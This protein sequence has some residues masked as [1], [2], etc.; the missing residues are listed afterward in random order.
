VDDLE[1]RARAYLH[2]N[3]TASASELRRALRCRKSV[4]LELASRIRS[5]TNGERPLTAGQL[6]Q[7]RSAAVKTGLHRRSFLPDELEEVDDIADAMR[8]SMP[9][10]STSFELA[11]QTTAMRVWRLR[12]AHRWLAEKGIEAA[13]GEA[14][15]RDLGTLDRTVQRDV[16]ALGI[17]PRSAAE[18][19]LDLKRLQME[20]TR[21]YDVSKLDAAQRAQLEELVEIME[22]ED[23]C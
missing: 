11:I 8:S 10:Y 9:T 2:A 22:A 5:Q 6:V 7:R 12:A 17:D 3:P 13:R 14:F 19:G 23:A 4:A 21:P 1:E 16:Q 20:N 15:F 18:L